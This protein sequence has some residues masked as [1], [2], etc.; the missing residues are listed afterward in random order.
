V[1]QSD[2]ALDRKDSKTAWD[3]ADQ[4]PAC[5]AWEGPFAALILRHYV[6]HGIARLIN[7]DLIRTLDEACNPMDC[8]HRKE[9]T[10]MFP[11]FD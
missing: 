10:T 8:I 1:H 9:I 7:Y 11:R 5:P 4:Q 6:E 2:Y 3:D